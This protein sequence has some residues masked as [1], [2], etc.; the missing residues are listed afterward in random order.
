MKIDWKNRKVRGACIVTM[1]ML[2][3][4]LFWAATDYMGAIAL[5]VL[6]LFVY[7]T[8]R[9]CRMVSRSSCNHWSLKF[10]VPFIGIALII[11]AFSWFVFPDVWEFLTTMGSVL[12]PVVLLFSPVFLFVSVHPGAYLLG[13]TIYYVASLRAFKARTNAIID[14]SILVCFIFVVVICYTGPITVMGR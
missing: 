13:C 3:N 4:L 9:I 12:P 2:L 14:I 7:A 11:F 10:N 8:F 5:T 6:E 1:L